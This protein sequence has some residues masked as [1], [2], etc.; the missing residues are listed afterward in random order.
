MK[1]ND[2]ILLLF[3]KLIAYCQNRKFATTFHWPINTGS[4][5]MYFLVGHTADFAIELS[6]SSRIVLNED[7]ESDEFVGARILVKP[8]SISKVIRFLQSSY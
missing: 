2:T 7:L 4:K 1:Y 8:F 6:T 5:V 3:D